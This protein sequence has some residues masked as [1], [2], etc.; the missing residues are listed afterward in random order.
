M[1][2]AQD[3]PVKY[4][5]VTDEELKMKSYAKDTSAA[6]VV[7]VD[8]G[9]S[10]F[11]VVNDK[12][13]VN[14]ERVLRIKVLKKSGYD[15]ANVTVPYYQQTSNSKELV[16][17]VKATTYNLENGQVVKVKM[18]NSA[19]FDEKESEH[20]YNKKFTLPAVKEGS[21][22]DISYLV[23]SDFIFNFRDWTFQSSIPVMHSEYRASI[24]EY[25]EYKNYMQGYE[26]L[27]VNETVPGSMNY[28]VRVGGLAESRAGARTP[29]ESVSNTIKTQN[30]RWVMKDLPAIASESFITTIQDY[31]SKIEFELEWIRYP[32]SAPERVAGNW[33]KLTD[34]FLEL[35]RFGVQLNR[36]GYF[37]AEVAA[38]QSVKDTLEK[39]NTIYD[40]VKKN[41]K[42]NN[43]GGALATSTL[44][45]AFD[46]KSGSAADIN[47][48]LVAMLRDAGLEADPVV[49]STRDHGRVPTHA[50]MINKFN[51]V[52][53]FVK[54]PKGDLLLDATDPFMPIGQLPKHCLNGQGWLVAKNKGSWIPLVPQTK[55]TELLNAELSILPT[56][57]MSGKVQESKTGMWA[58]NVR[59]SVKEDGETKYL[60]KLV[61][62]Q[63]EFERKKP[64]FK[65]LAQIQ[66]PISLEYEI[67]SAGDGQLKDIIYVNPMLLKDKQENPFKHTERKYPVDF[68][69]G[70]E[71]VYICNF[72]IPEGYMVEE[73]PKGV[74][75]SLPDNGG[76]FTYMLQQNGNKVQVMSKVTISKPIF[77]AQEYESLKQFYSQIVAKH[78]EQI[79]LKKKI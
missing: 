16:M 33:N 28:T 22:L 14:F 74:M 2:Q 54:T 4:G 75:M 71:E 21:V 52:V 36:T 32:G 25:Y 5:K 66:K 3:A 48:M 68:G 79:V 45:K 50:P 37:K 11:T 47:L 42:W 13:K 34:E 57:V 27:L 44:R 19:I 8:Y 55:S 20:W 1:A 9:R 18:E 30:H 12:M 7:L 40:F 70:S 10:F 38:L 43:K 69:H 73:M 41:V 53:A 72:T 35:D 23:S 62:A 6:A 76:K 77:Y 63:N 15:W 29:S 64:V 78:A 56:G 26:P 60:E 65:D 61:N 46:T 17:N 39:V 51:Y 31:I 59:N 58:V 49:L 24:P 67:S